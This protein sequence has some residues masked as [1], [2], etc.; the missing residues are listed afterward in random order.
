[1]RIQI[2]KQTPLANAPDELCY[3]INKWTDHEAFMSNDPNAVADF[4]MFNNTYFK[5]DIP[6]AIW[7]HSEPRWKG[8][9]LDC[10][11]LKLVNAQYH[12][13]LPEYADC[14]PVRNVIN[15]DK[16]EYA[17]RRVDGLRIAYS[18][19]SKVDVGEWH[20]KGYDETV[21]ALEGY[22]ADII[23]DT[24]LDECLRRKNACSVVIDECVTGS[25]HRSALEGLAMG[26]IA[27]G[28]LSDEVKRVVKDACGSDLPISNAKIDQLP[29]LLEYISNLSDYEMWI[30]CLHNRLWMS[31]NWHP[32]DIANE[33][34]KIYEE[35]I[36]D[37]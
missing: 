8:L 19:S 9:Q 4:I 6:A 31:I 13:T 18:P 17:Y 15:F 25:Y 27:I 7:Y 26:K 34:I 5:T 12:A 14:I 11:Y 10:P 29:C 3:A 28:N 37:K 23:T 35:V 32:K 2:S 30:E 36:N 20:R 22:D 21:K 33:F 24:P 16:P 1:M